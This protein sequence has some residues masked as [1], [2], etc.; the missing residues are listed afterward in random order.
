V[1]L[2]IFLVVATDSSMPP[3]IGPINDTGIRQTLNSSNP[4]RSPLYSLLPATGMRSNI[5]EQKLPLLPDIEGLKERAAIGSRLML[6]P[7]GDGL[8]SQVHIVLSALAYCRANNIT[9]IHKPWEHVGHSPPGVSIAAWSAGLEAFTGLVQNE[10]H[11]SDSLG[12]VPAVNY[13]RVEGD[14]VDRFFNHNFLQEMRARYMASPKNHSESF[15][16][17]ENSIRVAVHVR[18]GDVGESQPSRY[19][20]NTHELRF[21]NQVQV[22]LRTANHSRPIVFHIYS[23]G[24]A[25]TFD[26][27]KQAHGSERVFLHLNEDLKVT[28]HDMTAADVLIMAKS[29][30][31]YSAALLSAG[32]VYSQRFCLSALSYWRM[33]KQEKS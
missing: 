7:R 27:L 24:D 16:A 1:T 2:L 29:S 17:T 12:P 9:Y 5:S 6:F 28:F 19:T 14:D 4:L 11:F 15:L 31:S 8:G 3:L 26:E 32:Q 23:E 10:T 21:M 22:D 30:F 13:I 25:A 33:L 20:D 18:R